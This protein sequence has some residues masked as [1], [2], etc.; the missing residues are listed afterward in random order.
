MEELP[1]GTPAP[2]TTREWFAREFE[3]VTP[4]TLGRMPY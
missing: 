3:I 1:A 2:K 4:E